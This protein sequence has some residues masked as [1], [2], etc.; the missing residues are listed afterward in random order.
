MDKRVFARRLALAF[1]PFV[2]VFALVGWYNAARFGS[3]LDF[4]ANYNLTTNDMTHRE[5]Q[6]DRLPFALF[7]YLV[8]PPSVVLQYPYLTTTDLSTDYYGVNI[9]E[10]MWGGIFALTPVLL[11]SALLAMGQFRSRF[12]GQP[13]A[14]AVASVA[15]GFVLVVF[16]ANGAG[17]LMRYMMDF[18]FFFAFA[19]VLCIAQLWRRE[20]SELLVVGEGG[21]SRYCA[22]GVLLVA[23][24]VLSYLFQAMWL[25]GSAE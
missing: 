8:Q 16:D 22:V 15:I 18:G 4:G 1:V 5:F 17:V 21:A 10:N 14:L 7:A 23:L 13:L 24:V 19:A 6:L 2:V 9:F 25:L 3:P 12:A 20:G 11:V